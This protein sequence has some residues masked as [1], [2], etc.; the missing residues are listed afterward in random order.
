MD[1][2]KPISSVSGTVPEM[3][4]VKNWYFDLPGFAN[5][6][7]DY[8][9]QMEND[10][11]IR[12]VVTKTIKEFLVPPII[13]IK[14]ELYDAYKAIADKLPEHSYRDAEK[15]KQS[16]EIEFNSIGDR[17]V[18]RTV[19]TDAGIRFR[20]GK[21]LVPFR[22][23]GNVEW[24]VPVPVIE[25]AEGLTAWCW[26][27]SLWAPISFTMARND[28]RGLARSEWRTFWCDKE[29]CVYQFIG[30]DNLYFYG[31]AQPALFAA[32]QNRDNPV[33]DAPQG[34]LQQTKL[35]ANHHIL[36][37]D[38]KAS[39]S[40]DI[41][42]PTADELLNYYTAEQLRAHFLALAL[43]QRSVG[44]KPK[45]LSLIPQNAKTPCADP[46]SKKARFLRRC[47]TV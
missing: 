31:V 37:G 2:I 9:S 6:V 10:P 3:R 8:V 46:A 35:I 44:F 18:A 32:M 7:R 24:G 43:D 13:Y 28:N 11:Q 25:G 27:E 22:I 45:V 23:S 33:A 15:G 5:V 20:T 41:K 19:L 47:S 14:V 36:F 16:F 26:P 39:S 34:E 30:Q 1:L 29:S 40:S 4:E 17:D 12:P 42:P 38:K 21:A